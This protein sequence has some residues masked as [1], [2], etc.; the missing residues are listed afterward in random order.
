MSFDPAPIV[1][2]AVSHALSLG[3][4]ERVNGHEPQSAPGSGLTAAVWAQDLVPIALESGLAATS[5]RLTLN[6]R[7]YTSM[8]TIPADAVDPAMLTAVGLLMGAY[9]GD[10]TFGGLIRNV[11]IF[12]KHGVPLG[13]QAGYIRQDDKLLRVMTIAAPL[14][15][16]DCWEQEA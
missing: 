13:A 16:N 10:F 4:L 12:G 11:D 2:V 14:I 1:D 9:N 5:A 6:V 8:L 3:V 15:I 7:L